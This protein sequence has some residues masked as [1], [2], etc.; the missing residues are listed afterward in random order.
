MAQALIAPTLVPQKMLGRAFGPSRGANAPNAWRSTP[1][2]YAPRAPPPERTRARGDGA[3]S[4]TSR[5]SELEPEAGSARDRRQVEGPDVARGRAGGDVAADEREVHRH[6]GVE[7]DHHQAE[8]EASRR[9]EA[10]EH[11]RR[12]DVDGQRG[13]GVD[14]QYRRRDAEAGA[15]GRAR[16]L[17]PCAGAGETFAQLYLESDDREGLVA[18]QHVDGGL[19]GVADGVGGARSRAGE[20]GVEGRFQ[21]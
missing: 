8:L 17:V 12:L 16:A 2:S 20:M 9:A 10:D 3:A 1:T 5:A 19:Q 11:R 14:G 21:A 4:S 15:D 7:A 6:L 13:A 18:E